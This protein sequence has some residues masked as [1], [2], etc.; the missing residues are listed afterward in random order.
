MIQHRNFSDIATPNITNINS[1]GLKEFIV[2]NEA[3][4]IDVRTK[5]ELAATG[6][7][8]NSHNIPCMYN[9]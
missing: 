6:V 3:L 7:I 5:E 8:P 1:N 4:I 2:Q 9:T